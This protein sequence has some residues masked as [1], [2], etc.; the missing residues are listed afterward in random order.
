MAD[1]AVLLVE[2]NGLADVITVIRG[3]IE[4]VQ[5]PEMVDVVVSEPMGFLLVHE[6]MLESYLVGRDRFLKPAVAP[7]M[8]PSVGRIR[9][10]PFSDAQLHAE[11]A[12]KT[13]FWRTTDFF[14]VNMSVL[15]TYASQQSFAQPVIGCVDPAQFIAAEEQMCSHTINFETASIA[16]LNEIEVPFSFRISRNSLMHG[17]VCWFDVDFTGSQNIVTLS[18]SPRAPTT[19]WYQ[20]R[21]LLANPLGVN[22]G[23]RVDGRVLMRANEKFSYDVLLECRITGTAENITSANQVSLNDPYYHYLS[24]NG[25]QGSPQ[26]NAN[27]YASW[28]RRPDAHEDFVSDASSQT[29]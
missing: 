15:E 19:H 6:R 2:A 21:L 8:F 25:V 4:E 20:I 13:L 29:D 1:M 9:V 24:T 14:G 12:A 28:V 5:L 22:T 18:T 3:K 10:M 16:D 17:V 7:R 27:P 23:Q 26:A 11:Q